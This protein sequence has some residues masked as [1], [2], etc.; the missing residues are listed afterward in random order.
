[1]WQFVFAAPLLVHGLAHASG[2]LASWSSQDAGYSDEPWIFSSGVK[3]DQGLGRVFGAIW[4]LAA[5]G[6][7][8]AA[9]GVVTRQTWWV[10]LAIPA[11]VASLVAIA[12]WWNTVP[13]GARIGALFDLIVL[14]ALT[15]PWRETII[16][17][18]G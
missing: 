12:P 14:A 10:L 15:L 16:E 8:A 9:F 2:F 11:A 5:I 13:P 7:I 6:F 4:L 3:L 17:L 1:M 18:V